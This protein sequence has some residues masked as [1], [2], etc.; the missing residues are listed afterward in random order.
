MET[1]VGADNFRVRC[2]K[3]LDAVPSCRR[4]AVGRCRR[5]SRSCPWTRLHEPDASADPP[6]QRRP[7]EKSPRLADGW[8]GL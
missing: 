8:S 1:T 3:L 6:G 4:P 2:L 7:W 5:Q